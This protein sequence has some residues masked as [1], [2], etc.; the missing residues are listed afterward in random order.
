MIVLDF[1]C[2]RFIR[3]NNGL[4]VV[5]DLSV[6][7][8]SRVAII[9]STILLD[10]TPFFRAVPRKIWAPGSDLETRVISLHGF[11]PLHLHLPIDKT[12]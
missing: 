12:C 6:H 7:I 10:S 9:Q 3:S 1:V 5:L 8:T 2:V 4:G 11:D